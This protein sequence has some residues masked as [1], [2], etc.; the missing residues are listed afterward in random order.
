MVFQMDILLLME[1][2]RNIE[3]LEHHLQEG[4]QQFRDNCHNVKR[5]L[6]SIHERYLMENIRDEYT[7]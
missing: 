6:A 7:Q 3:T 4:L 1:I 2:R 5:S